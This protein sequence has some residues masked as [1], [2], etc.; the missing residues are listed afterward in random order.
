MFN[1]SLEQLK[2]LRHIK[3]ADDA[4]ERIRTRLSLYTALKP[5]VIAVPLE[6]EIREYSWMSFWRLRKTQALMASLLLVVTSSSAI[7][8]AERTLPGDILYPVKVYVNEGV[9]SLFAV[10]DE[11]RASLEVSRLSRRLKEAEALAVQGRLSEDTEEKLA[12]SIG[13]HAQAARS[14]IT[15]ASDAARNS[16]VVERIQSELISTIAAHDGVLA[17]ILQ[18]NKKS[19]VLK[20]VQL[21]VENEIAASATTSIAVAKN[22]SAQASRETLKAIQDDISTLS[23]N[24]LNLQL[25]FGENEVSRDR[26]K[27]HVRQLLADSEASRLLAIEAVTAGNIMGARVYLNNANRGYQE[28]LELFGSVSLLEALPPSAT[29]TNATSSDTA[30]VDEDVK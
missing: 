14:H 26:S 1:Q 18:S 3:L 30:S 25:V 23:T 12:S 10:S 21:V 24:L 17:D 20:K 27:A 8:A 4:R 22:T 11:S 5:S 13:S 2:E 19:G 28:L 16:V 15:S 29:T 7:H 9:R 6:R